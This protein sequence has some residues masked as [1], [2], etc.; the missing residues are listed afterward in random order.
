V[1]NS[2]IF[3]ILNSNYLKS[4]FA[5]VGGSRWYLNKVV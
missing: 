4:P 2:V 1:Q 5:V 3:R